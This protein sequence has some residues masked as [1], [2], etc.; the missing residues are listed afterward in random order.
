M[1]YSPLSNVSIIGGVRDSEHIHER[2][3]RLDHSN[4]HCAIMSA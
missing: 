2:I 4:N 1:K 3:I